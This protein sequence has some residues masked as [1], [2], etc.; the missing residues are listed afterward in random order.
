MYSF[1]TDKEISCFYGTLKFI[2]FIFFEVFVAVTVQIVVF[3]LMTTCSLV[4]VRQYLGEIF[5]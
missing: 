4:G 3:C 5:C 1:M 2:V